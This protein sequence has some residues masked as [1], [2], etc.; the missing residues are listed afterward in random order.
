MNKIIFLDIDGVLNNLNHFKKINM[1]KASYTSVDKNCVKY[2]NYILDEDTQV[3]IS[4][5]WRLGDDS[6]YDICKKSLSDAGFIGNIHKDWRT[7]WLFKEDGIIPLPRGNEILE[8]LSRHP[9]ITNFVCLDDD[10]DFTK[11]CNLVKTCSNAGLTFIDA[12]KAKA[13]LGDELSKKFI[14][15]IEKSKTDTKIKGIISFI[16]NQTLYQK[17]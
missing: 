3:V 9:E 14:L 11:E 5:T 15:N 7:K 6:V 10:D 13:V 2:L 1:G 17:D 16:N 8:W 12:L 4:S